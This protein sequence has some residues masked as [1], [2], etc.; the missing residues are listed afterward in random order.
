MQIEQKQ[1]RARPSRVLVPVGCPYAPRLA[2]IERVPS[3]R[4]Y[5]LCV[6]DGY[7]RCFTLTSEELKIVACMMCV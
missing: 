6:Q 7:G 3:N 4:M 5:V 1:C 2:A